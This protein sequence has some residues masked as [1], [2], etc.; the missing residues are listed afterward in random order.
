MFTRLFVDSQPVSKA[1][2]PAARRIALLFLVL[3]VAA[4]VLF[5][6]APAGKSQSARITAEQAIALAIQGETGADDF[7]ISDM[8]RPRQWPS[9]AQRMST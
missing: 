9:T 3:A 5:V 2:L 1:S 7:R 8:G 4:A 6:W